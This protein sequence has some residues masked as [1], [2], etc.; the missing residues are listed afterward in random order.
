MATFERFTWD[1]IYAL[2]SRE[3]EVGEALVL[4]PAQV[5]GGLAAAGAQAKLGAPGVYQV[6]VSDGSTL[7]VDASGGEWRLRLIPGDLPWVCWQGA[8]LSA[9]WLALPACLLLL[10]VLGVIS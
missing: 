7:E 2:L 8:G 1:E 5:E 4:H 6:E 9:G 3:R 10:S